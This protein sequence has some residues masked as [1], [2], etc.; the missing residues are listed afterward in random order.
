[1][2]SPEGSAGKGVKNDFL[3]RLREKTGL[4]IRPG[5]RNVEVLVFEG[6]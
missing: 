6:R 4:V 3:E 5:Q 1:M 2:E